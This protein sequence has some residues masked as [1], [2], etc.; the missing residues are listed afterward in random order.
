MVRAEFSEFLN[1][2]METRVACGFDTRDLGNDADRSKETRK[3]PT[4]RWPFSALD[5]VELTEQDI[6]R[7]KLR[8]LDGVPAYN[9]PLAGKISDQLVFCQE[10]L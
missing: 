6:D 5:A 1:S 9:I 8:S 10:R 7:T 2:R 3:F 4:N